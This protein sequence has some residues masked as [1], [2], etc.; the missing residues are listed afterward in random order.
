M[1]ELRTAK[2]RAALAIAMADIAGAWDVNKVTGEL[3]RFADAC[4][5]GA[6]RFLL[7]AEAARA[8]ACRRCAEEALRPH[9]AGDGQI[10]RL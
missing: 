6:L 3:T 5:G 8:R 1:K 7:R 2:R 9:R 10:R 4:V